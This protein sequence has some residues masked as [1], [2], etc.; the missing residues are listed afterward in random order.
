MLTQSR[1][2]FVPKLDRTQELERGSRTPNLLSSCRARARYS[3]SKKTH[4]ISLQFYSMDCKITIL[5]SM[6][7]GKATEIL[8][9][10]NP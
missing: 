2:N 1:E 10:Y 4:F 8:V 7:I 5:Q 3:P 6:V 9:K